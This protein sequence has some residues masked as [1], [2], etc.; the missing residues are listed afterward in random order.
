MQDIQLFHGDCLEVMKYIPDK[1]IDLILTDP[2]YL[3]NYKTNRRKN[4]EHDFCNPIQ[5]D[6]NEEV[7]KKSIVEMARLLK[8]TGALYVFCNANKIEIFK[9]IISELFI[10]KN[11]LIWVKNNHTAGDL[12]GAY[13]KKTEF[14]IYATKGKHYL[15]GK[16]DTDVLF[17][18]K[19]SG[20]RQIHQNEKPIDLLEFIISKSSNINDIVLDCF[21][22]SGTTGV[23]AKNLNRRF[24][25]IEL[26]KEYFE[27]AKKR[28]ESPVKLEIKKDEVNAN[29][30]S[31]F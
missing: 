12:K 9:K 10:F 2:P 13:G 20:K 11:I 16:R 8:D 14:I 15:N 3:M 21:M 30:L 24:I 25:G 26:D 19:V 1:S 22:G 5:N 28:I 6:D 27:I 4:K 29:Q 7:V 31:L 17:Y 18:N 23:A